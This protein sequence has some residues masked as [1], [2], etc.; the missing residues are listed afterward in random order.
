MIYPSIRV[1]TTLSKQYLLVQSWEST[2]STPRP[3]TSTTVARRMIGNALQIRE[4]QRSGGPS[5]RKQR[6]P[7]EE[8][9]DYWAE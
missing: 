7:K 6:Q 1:P 4:L 3:Q 8:K 9:K 2:S 5:P